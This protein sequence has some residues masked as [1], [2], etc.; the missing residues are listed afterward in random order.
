VS[1]LHRDQLRD[2]A[3]SAIY[4]GASPPTTTSP[5]L[6]RCR[7]SRR[8]S[9]RP[10]RTVLRSSRRSERCDNDTRLPRPAC[11]QIGASQLAKTFLGQ[12]EQAI[13]HLRPCPGLPQGVPQGRARPHRLQ[14]QGEA[15]QRVLRPRRAEAH[16]RHPYQGVSANIVRTGTR[17]LTAAQYQQDRPQEAQDPPVAPSSPDQQWRFHQ[18][19]QGHH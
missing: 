1:R 3:D 5:S 4:V 14:A 8:P 15:E 19:D 17:L 18:G 10:P 16:L 11:V 7:R 6:R 9:P 12:Q 13:G 2:I